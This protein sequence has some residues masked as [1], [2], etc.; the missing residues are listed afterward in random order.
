MALAEFMREVSRQPL[1]IV[2]QYQQGQ[3]TR[4]AQ[5]AA[6]QDSQVKQ[7]QLGKYHQEMQDQQTKR[8]TEAEK[9]ARL[10]LAQAAAWADTPEKHSQVV[11]HYEGKG[12]PIPDWYRTYS[13][14]N[15]KRAV[16]SLL[17][18]T[19]LVKATGLVPAEI[20]LQE[21]YDETS[22]TKTRLG[23]PQQALGQPGAP[24]KSSANGFGTEG[25]F[26]GRSLEAQAYNVLLN[27]DPSS[28][29]YALAYA[30][31]TQP[32]TVMGEQGLMQ[33]TPRLPPGIRPPTGVAQASQPQEAA[34]QS[35]QPTGSAAID[36]SV[37]PG[38]EKKPHYTEGEL[39]ASGFVSRMDAAEQLLSDPTLSTEAPSYGSALAGAVPFVGDTLR[40]M[41]QNPN[42]QKFAQ[43]ASDWI[44]AKLRK[45]SGAV[46]GEDEIDREFKTYF[47]TVGDSPEVIAQKA[48]ARR[49]ATE[50]MRSQAGRAATI[51]ESRTRGAI[52]RSKVGDI[53]PINGQ[54]YRIVRLSPDGDHDVELAQ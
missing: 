48:D 2:D 1:N 39:A 37:V 5:M 38:T 28:P 22:P 36:V 42:T 12:V 17:E 9:A 45:E 6:Q 4:L 8:R 13:P 43:A 31:A 21:Y 20:K 26:S 29:Q 14:D 51:N 3:N 16:L 40:N 23:T 52:D 24:S 19:D 18:G 27:G 7:A 34:P 11:Q 44:R 53:I 47:P 46:I 33:I 35:G 15:R 32:R 50:A 54:Q 49:V 41:V 10:E 30:H 25:P